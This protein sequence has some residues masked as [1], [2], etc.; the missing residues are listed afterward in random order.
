MQQ[1]IIYLQNNTYRVVSKISF[2]FLAGLVLNDH[3]GFNLPK[4]APLLFE[5]FTDKE[6]Q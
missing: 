4:K 6:P 1:G 5:T 3:K 2:P